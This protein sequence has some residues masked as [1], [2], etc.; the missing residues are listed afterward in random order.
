MCGWST[1]RTVYGEGVWLGVVSRC[2]MG[3]VHERREDV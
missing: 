1:G 2:S 3:S